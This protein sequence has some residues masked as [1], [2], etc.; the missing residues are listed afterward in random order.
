M[1][2]R[3]RKSA[4]SPPVLKAVNLPTETDVATIIADDRA[5]TP[6]FAGLLLPDEPGMKTMPENP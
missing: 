2:R 3:V 6:V 4:R 5:A 1:F